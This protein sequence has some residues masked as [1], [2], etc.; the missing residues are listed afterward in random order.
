MTQ[1]VAK[2]RVGGTGTSGVLIPEKQTDQPHRGYR[3]LFQPPGK[4]KPPFLSDRATK[5]S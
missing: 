2:N 1:G 3:K 4:E 5:E